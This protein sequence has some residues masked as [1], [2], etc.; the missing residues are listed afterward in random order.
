M[1]R[2]LCLTGLVLLCSMGS[3]AQA[4][5]AGGF[6][7]GPGFVA[8]GLRG[9]VVGY[10]TYTAV[11]P[12]PYVVKQ[13]FVAPAPVITSYQYVAPAPVVTTTTIP[14]YG[15]VGQRS[16][17]VGPLGGQV[18]VGQWNGPYGSVGV[19]RGIGPFGGR[20]IAVFGR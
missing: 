5:V 1:N 10:P 11:A 6:V 15:I 16:T 13:E 20:G 8:G 2:L 7:A 14:N 4:Q 9:P 3:S 18:T 17:F 19:I 12:A